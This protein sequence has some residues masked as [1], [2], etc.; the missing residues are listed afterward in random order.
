MASAVTASFQAAEALKL[1]TASPARSAGYITLDLWANSV[2]YV[3]V[4]KN[5]A[6]PVCAQGRYEFL[7]KPPRTCLLPCQDAVQV[8]PNS[9]AA[10]DFT[11][12]GAALEKYGMV[13]YGG[14]MLGFENGEVQFKLFKDGRALVFGVRDE[15]A[16]RSVYAQ[17][18]GL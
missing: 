3:E 9:A 10:V 13:Q 14:Y 11:A 17:Y 12:L 1:L 6:C 18:I 15:G 7:G 16:A 5:D 4:K 2:E 8:F